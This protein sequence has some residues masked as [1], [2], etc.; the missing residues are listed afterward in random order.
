MDYEQQ[1]YE[2]GDDVGIPLEPPPGLEPLPTAAR[3]HRQAQDA[4]AMW[5][6]RAGSSR[7]PYVHPD[8]WRTLS[9]K[10]RRE[11]ASE[12]HCEVQ[13]AQPRDISTQTGLMAVLEICTDEASTLG[14]VVSEA[15]DSICRFTAA[16]DFRKPETLAK[17][18]QDVKRFPGCHVMISIPCVAGS[19]WQRLNLKRG[20][21]RQKLRVASL[22]RDMLLLLSNCRVLARAVRGAGGSIS[23]EWPRGCSL[24]REE[25]VQKFMT[26]FQLRAVDFDGCS[27]GLVSTTGSPLLKP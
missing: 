18:L 12:H 1:F 20:G 6:T 22:R 26:D 10:L 15:G 13:A 3:Q 9:I 17:S 5:P 19:V 2:E 24:W 4:A 11:L 7:P 27:V 25:A 21:L 23:F 8:L 14:Q 16:D